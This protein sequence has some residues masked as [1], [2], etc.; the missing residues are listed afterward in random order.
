M[1]FLV[2]RGLEREQ[3]R[4]KNRLDRQHAHHDAPVTR[5]KHLADPAHRPSA[6]VSKSTG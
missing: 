2:A 4:E 3:K 1:N 5:R 6:D